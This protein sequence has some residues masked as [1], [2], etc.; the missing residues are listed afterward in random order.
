MSLKILSLA[1]N[2]LIIPRPGRVELGT[3]RLGRKNLFFTVQTLFAPLEPLK[4]MTF[5]YWPA[6]K[7]VA[8]PAPEDAA[9]KDSAHVATLYELPV[10]RLSID[11]F[12]VLT[13][14][15]KEKTWIKAFM[16]SKIRLH[17][18]EWLREREGDTIVDV[19]GGERNSRIKGRRQK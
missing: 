2:N 8:G 14:L 3:S 11:H 19:V 9:H 6:S 12:K 16:A 15:F 13:S 10:L 18:E 7:L 1:G 4:N 5:L 17:R